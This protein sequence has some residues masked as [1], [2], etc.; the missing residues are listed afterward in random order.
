MGRSPQGGDSG[1]DTGKGVGQGAAG[2]AHGRGTG[3]LLVV[4]MQDEEQIQGLLGHRID[5][6][7]LAGRG[8]HHVQQIGAIGEIIAGYMIGSPILCL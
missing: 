4:R 5:L 7:L 3:V 6:I 8:E 2:Q 1:S